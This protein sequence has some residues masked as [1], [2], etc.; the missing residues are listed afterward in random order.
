MVLAANPCPC[1]NAVG[2]AVDCRC[3]SVDRRRYERRLSG[4]LLDRVDI[5]LVVH[6]PALDQWSPKQATTSAQARERVTAARDR[7]AHRAARLGLR[8]ALN[9]R[10]PGRLLRGELAPDPAAASLLSEAVRRGGLSARAADRA[11]RVA[12]TISDREGAAKPGVKQVGAA[13]ALRGLTG[14]SPS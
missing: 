9:A 5:Q 12:W 6:A 1:G 8:S 13:L 14:G 4:P 11:V 3:T 10:L 7:A 2:N